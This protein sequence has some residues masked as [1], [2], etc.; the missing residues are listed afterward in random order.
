ML[1]PGRRIVSTLA[2]DACTVARLYRDRITDK[3]YIRLSGT[4]MAAPM[5]SGAAAL[6]LQRF[7]QLSPNQIKWLLT[8]TA[9]AYAG[10]ADAA[11]VLDIA[12]AMHIADVGKIGSANQGLT[13]N[14]GINAATGTVLWG[15]A[16]WDQAYW[17][18]AYWDQAYWDQALPID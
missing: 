4:S 10:Q 6:L 18:Q 13:P 5:V 8:G 3:N 12:Q 14:T 15:Q 16:Y 9:R 1:A 11:S 17:D 7:P 2:S